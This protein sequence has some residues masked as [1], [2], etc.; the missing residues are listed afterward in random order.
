MANRGVTMALIALVAAN[1]AVAAAWIWR[2]QLVEAGVP[3]PA[4]SLPSEVVLPVQPLSPVAGQGDAVA[5]SEVGAGT[6]PESTALSATPANAAP[7]E[8]PPPAAQAQPPPEPSVAAITPGTALDGKG[9][10]PE[11]MLAGPFTGRDLAARIQAAVE[12]E[13]G[14]ADIEAVRLPP[15]Y[16]VHLAPAASRTAARLARDGLAARGVNAYVMGGER[17]NGV[18]VGVFSTPE[19]AAAQRDRVANLGYDD[20]RV[21]KDERP[22]ER[23]RLRVRGVAPA[24]LG[25]VAWE[26]CPG[27]D[28]DR[29]G[30]QEAQ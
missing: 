12:A 9:V 7:V 1:L 20:V 21:S 2:E 22:A 16:V 10:A 3:L 14:E 27:T 5:G 24:L 19:R 18:S 26:P 29:G 28:A 4:A 11:C 8:S 15:R 23:Y 30:P 17:R 25:T 13:G 6:Q